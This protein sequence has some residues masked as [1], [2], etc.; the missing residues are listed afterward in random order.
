MSAPVEFERAGREKG[1]QIWRI[2]QFKPV[3]ILTSDYGKFFTG[4]SYIVLSVN[5]HFQSLRVI[6]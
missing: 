6:L 3:P 1:L 2:E 4:D 5:T